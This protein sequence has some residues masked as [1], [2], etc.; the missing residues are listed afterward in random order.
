MTLHDKHWVCIALTIHVGFSNVD[1]VGYHGILHY[2]SY[3]LR[4]G[5]SGVVTWN[6][7]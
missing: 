6:K 5:L 3:A 2:F 7:I 4:N 1:M